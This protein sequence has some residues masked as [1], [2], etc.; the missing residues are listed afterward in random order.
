MRRVLPL[1]FVGPKSPMGLVRV[2]G[3]SGE[4][5]DPGQTRHVRWGRAYL[6]LQNVP[7]L[8]RWGC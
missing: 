4:K 3:N 7:H 5:A 6:S 1:T 8:A 2:C